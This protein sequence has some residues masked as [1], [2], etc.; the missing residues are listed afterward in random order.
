MHLYLIEANASLAGHRRLY[1]RAKRNDSPEAFHVFLVPDRYTLGVEKELCRYCFPDGYA[2]ADVQSFTRYAIKTI[3]KKLKKP[4]SKEGTVILLKKIVEQNAD[5][6]KYYKKLTGYSFAKE[7]FAAIASLRSGGV[8]LDRVFATAE[9]NEGVFYDKLHDIALIGREYD[10]VL[11]EKYSD[12]I[13]RMD[14]LNE[15]LK[16]ADLSDT[17]FYVLGFNVYSQQQLDVIATLAARSAGVALSYVRLY[18]TERCIGEQISALRARCEANDVPVLKE[19]AYSVVPEPFDSIRKGMFVGG[20]GV[21]D[22]MGKIVLFSEEDPYSEATAVAREITYLV[23]KENYRYRDVALVCNNVDLLPVIY[24]TFDRCDIPCFIDE[25]YKVADGAFARFVTAAFAAA[26]KAAAEDYFRLSRQALTGLQVE[27]QEV[28]RSYCLKYNVNY[29][30]FDKPFSIGDFDKAEAVRQKL[31]AIVKKIRKCVSVRDFCQV[32]SDFLC[33]EEIKGKLDEMASSDDER[34]RAYAD[35]EGINKLVIELSF[36]IGED[37]YS[38]HDFLSTF[39]AAIADMKTVLRPEYCDTVF[40]GNTEESRFNDVKAIFFVGASDGFFPIKSGDGLIFTASDNERLR[41]NGMTVFPSPVEKN[42][43]ERF[44]VRDL[45][46]KPTERLYVGCS[47]ADLSGEMQSFGEGMEELKVLTGTETVKPLASFRDLSDNDA[48]NY[49][50]V[51][52][53]NAYYE[54]LCDDI[55]A[56]YRASVKKLFTKHGFLAEKTEKKEEV[57]TGFFQKQGDKYLT[58]ISQ[59]QDYFSC[60]FMH[61]IKRGLSI[62]PEED[63][64][65]DNIT[66]GNIVHKVMELFF[67]NHLDKVYAGKNYD[68]ELNAVLDRVF[69]DKDYEY[70]YYNPLYRYYLNR[71]RVECRRAVDAISDNLR[72]SKFRPVGFEVGFGY[73][74]DDK[75]ILINANNE[76]FCLRGKIDRVDQYNGYVVIVDYKTGALGKLNDVYYGTKIQLYVYL[77]KYLNDGLKPAGVFYQPLP[78]SGKN[79]ARYYGLTG[80]MLDD[81]DIFRAL[82]DRADALEE[83]ELSSSVKMRGSFSSCSEINELFTSSDFVAVTDYVDKLISKALCEI[84]EGYAE[85]KPLGNCGYCNY[86]KLCGIRAARAQDNVNLKNFAED[87]DD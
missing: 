6:L 64:S 74:N 39:V 71:L 82:D 3:G 53:K 59:L 38:L 18:G 78:S 47:V 24:E 46:S 63:Y 65:L 17:Y 70:F 30:R 32:I 52:I 19:E 26:D 79:A 20:K 84:G 66:T 21:T 35:V 31:D 22:P 58:S 16:T 83:K 77:K 36:L 10:R 29:T 45:L 15:Y 7:L 42:S 14:A 43:F 2:R 34:I 60:P 85:K 40:I 67:K 81:R 23:K 5:K 37:R 50:L 62:R 76:Q 27:E 48:L 73:L 4:L 51:N 49:L 72:H 9:T 41:A 69:S 57:F 25:G 54:Y 55:P 61:F 33:D 1:E 56:K 86:V 13:T 8:S 75:T 87:E 44:I 11:K 28:F 68:K 80:Q 12:A